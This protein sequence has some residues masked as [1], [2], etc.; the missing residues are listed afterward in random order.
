MLSKPAVQAFIALA[1]KR[2][3]VIATATVSLQEQLVQRDIPRFL[4]RMQP[5]LE[6]LG[7]DHEVIFC[8][9]PSPDGSE[10]AILRER[11]VDGVLVGGASLDES[12]F[13][14]IVRF[15]HHLLTD[16]LLRRVVHGDA[17][18]DGAR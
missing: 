17:A 6:T 11:D 5:I 4:A 12:E 14:S 15:E 8:L 1:H 10:Q 7:A 16:Q 9:D 13:A 3:L 2:P 18:D